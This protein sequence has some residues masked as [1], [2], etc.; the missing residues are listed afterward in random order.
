[1]DYS[2]IFIQI[3]DH[4]IRTHR[5]NGPEWARD[6]AH[7]LLNRIMFLYFIARKGWL[8]G[9]DGRPDRDFMRHFWEAYRQT[10][11]KDAFHRDWL[12]VLLFEAFNNRWQNRADYL[13]RFPQWLVNSLAQA[14]FLNGGLYSRRP[15]LDDRL[16]QPVPDEFFAL[17]FERWTDSTFPG[18]FERY[19]FTVVESGRFDEEV[20]V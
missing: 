10:K 6:Y 2:E 18:L 1:R 4:L 5:G 17:L 20:A 12:D 3:R 7:Q 14:P 19:N 16:T 15:G 11:G 8:L 13:R 9:P